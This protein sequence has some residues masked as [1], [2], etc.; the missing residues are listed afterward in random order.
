MLKRAFIIV[1]LVLGALVVV[2]ALTVPDQQAH[3]DAVRQLAQSVVEK[4]LTAESISDRLVKA[5]M[6]KLPELGVDLSEEDLKNLGVDEEDL[7]R[8]GAQGLAKIGEDMDLTEVK[9]VGT[10][11]A[12]GAA[13]MYLRSHMT[14]DNYVVVNIGWVTF[15]GH[16]LPITIG[17]FGK[18][19]I[20]A[21]ENQVR[22]LI[23]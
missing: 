17:A 9:E 2:M 6:E 13:D 1:T 14:V 3:Y 11:M 22:Q 15:H 8:L 16:T 7:T 20:L 21:D 10:Q 23:K 12:M 4:E 19:F 18:V 5:G